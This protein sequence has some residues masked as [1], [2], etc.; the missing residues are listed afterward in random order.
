MS[1]E[2]R[3]PT[4]DKTEDNAYFPSP[5]SLTQYVAPK[6]DFD[7]VENPGGYS[8]GRWKVLVIATEERYL[9][10]SG[11]FFS[12]GNHPV[13]TFL[14]I[15]HLHDTGFGI[16]IATPSGNPGK[17][18]HWAMPAD[19]DAVKDTY[20]RFIEDWRAPK[21]LADVVEGD[22]GPD[23]DYLAVFIPGGH[24]A[25]NNLPRN[26][27]VARVLDWALENDRAIITLCH[28]PAA[29]L[30]VGRGR[31]ESPLR[32]YSACVFPDALDSGQNI[33]LGYIPGTL[34]WL[35]AD[36]LEKQGL[37][38]VND[39]MSGATHRDRNLLTGDSPLAAN[40]LGKMS[41][42]YLLERAGELE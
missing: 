42:N 6:T 26:P 22:L 14:P 18:E 9:P 1:N 40:T 16:D 34:P 19:D 30:S 24:G 17:L 12:T 27:L 29:L 10:T 2:D 35:V 15:K 39:D 23:S 7:G 32:G 37:T 5:F 13:E 36:E 21:N 25:M 11:G 4:I 31:A 33:G 41:A 20:A 28:G 8:G 38:V 3:S